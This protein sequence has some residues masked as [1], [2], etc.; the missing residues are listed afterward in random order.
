MDLGWATIRGR[1]RW[2][3][4]LGIVTALALI[5]G[6]LVALNRSV[7]PFGGWPTGPQSSA[8]EQFLPEAPSTIIGVLPNGGTPA[9]AG[10]GGRAVRGAPLA[11]S[12]PVAGTGGA[13]APGADVGTGGGGLTF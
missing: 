7:L 12:A 4:V 5:A 11:R 9:P 13:V 1:A 10:L 8:G 2:A 6:S 3:T